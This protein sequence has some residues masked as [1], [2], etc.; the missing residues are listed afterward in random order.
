MSPLR[1]IWLVWCGLWTL[2][3]MFAGLLTFGLAWFLAL[4]SM[5]LML[6]VLIPERPRLAIA[7]PCMNCGLASDQH[8]AGRCPPRQM[9]GPPEISR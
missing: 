7:P 9:A 8:W 3:W 6:L 5:G 2:F 1:I 4:G